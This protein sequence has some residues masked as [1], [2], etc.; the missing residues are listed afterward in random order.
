MST[1]TAAKPRADLVIANATDVMTCVSTAE[2]LVGRRSGVSVAIGGERIIAVGPPAEIAQQVDVSSAEVLDASGKIVVPGFVDCHT[3]LVFGGSRVE[4]YAARLTMNADEVQVLGVPTGIQATVAMTRAESVD[5]LTAT[6]ADRVQRMFR[7][8]TTTLESKSGYGLSLA[9]EIKLLEVNQ[10]LQA[11]QPM[12][13]VST[14]LGAH[15]FLSEL[16]RA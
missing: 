12:D 4:E 8:G 3:H 5:E 15:D 10:R 6:A 9:E 16:P 13:V 2:D 1:A 11:S 7:H 14:F